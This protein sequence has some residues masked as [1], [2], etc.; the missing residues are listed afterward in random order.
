M[1]T[2]YFGEVLFLELSRDGGIDERC[3]GFAIQA[4]EAME[5]L[6]ATE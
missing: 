3:Q 1:E 2:K 5:K 6:A 4:V